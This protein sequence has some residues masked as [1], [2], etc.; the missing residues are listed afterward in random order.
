MAPEAYGAPMEYR[1]V[2]R[3]RR[4]VRHYTDE[5]L[6]PEVIE[7]SALRPPSGGYSQGWAFLTLTEA[8]DRERFW[9]FVPDEVIHR[10]QWGR[11]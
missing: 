1:E 2:I 4:M 7:R 8:E 11:P 5:P 6:E 3:R 9:P 10:G